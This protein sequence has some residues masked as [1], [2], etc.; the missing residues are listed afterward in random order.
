MSKISDYR[1][2][3]FVSLKDT[4][5]EYVPVKYV[6]VEADGIDTVM[7]THPQVVYQEAVLIIIII[8]IHPRL[9]LWQVVL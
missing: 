1:I 8:L 5:N 2:E 3:K 7:L 9:G 4:P 6:T